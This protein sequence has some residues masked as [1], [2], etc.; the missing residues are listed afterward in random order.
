[1]DIYFWLLI[2]IIAFL[3][4]LYNP[5]IDPQAN[6][7]ISHKYQLSDQENNSKIIVQYQGNS[8]DITKFIDKHPGGSDLLI[9]NANMDIEQLMLDNEHSQSAYKI[10]DKYKI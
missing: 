6:F 10:L 3:L 7:P 8:Y 4:F 9:Q 1:M 2:G 5:L